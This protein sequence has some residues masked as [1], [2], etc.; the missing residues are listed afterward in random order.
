MERM[1]YGLEQG[2]RSS[3]ITLEVPRKVLDRSRAKNVTALSQAITDGLVSIDNATF[4]HATLQFDLKKAAAST[5]HKNLRTVVGALVHVHENATP[6][7]YD[8]MLRVAMSVGSLAGST[9]FGIKA[10]VTWPRV[11]NARMEIA[12]SNATRQAALHLNYGVERT[13][14]NSNGHDSAVAEMI[15]SRVIRMGGVWLHLNQETLR[16]T[17]RSMLA[18]DH[19]TYDPARPTFDLLPQSIK[20]PEQQLLGLVGAIALARPDEVA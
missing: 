17:D 4:E 2:P 14:K 15:S 5:P 12:A 3:K 6:A 16:P 13:R 10:R 8:P 20:S 9:L 1:K 7:Q 19:A 11:S 18:T